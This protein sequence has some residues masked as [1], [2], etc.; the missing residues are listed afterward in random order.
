MSLV[1]FVGKGQSSQD[2]EAIKKVVNAFQEDFNEGS[3]KMP[4][5]IQRPI[6]DTS[7][8]EEVSTKDVTAF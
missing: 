7:I 4:M 2:K 8:P 3:F 6:G 5:P 1:S